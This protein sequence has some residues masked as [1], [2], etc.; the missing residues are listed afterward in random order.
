MKIRLSIWL[1]MLAA[2]FVVTLAVWH[3]HSRSSAGLAE[4]PTHSPSTHPMEELKPVPPTKP[5]LASL[6][7]PTVSAPPLYSDRVKAIIDDNTGFQQRRQA[8][9]ALGKKL[10][11]ADREALYDFLRQHSSADGRQPEQVLKNELM[12]ALCQMQPPPTGLRDLLTQLYQDSSQDLVL[13]DYAVQHLTAFYQQMGAAVGVEAQAQAEDLAQTRQTLWSAL[14]DTDTS[15][16][17][18]A[19]LGLSQLSQAGW[20]GFDPN[21][22]G[23]AAL[24]MAGDS[25]A[26]ELARITA[27]QV[28]A[29]LG[30]KDALPVIL[31]AAQ[32]GDTVP[33]QI[34]AIA[35]LG[36]LGDAG[37][38]PFLNRLLQGTNDRLRLPAQHAL[39]QINARSKSL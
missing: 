3:Q 27:L 17:G 10:S 1:M 2:V 21:Q 7:P 12:N 26:G 9:L 8:V 28:C 15:I 20:P 34:S 29:S 22:I 39:S 33:V 24:K 37:E 13:R 4:S 19:L 14:N 18:T 31:N 25:G 36:A 6:P 30:T 32:Q 5:M 38:I 16:A 23:A 35:A 11:D